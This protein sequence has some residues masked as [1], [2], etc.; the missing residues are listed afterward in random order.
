MSVPRLTLEQSAIIGAFT[1]VLCG[2]FSALHR[3]AEQ[4]LGT[5]I[6]THQFADPLVAAELKAAAREDFYGIC[7][8]E[9]GAGPPEVAR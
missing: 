8:A 6:W 2:P 5:P 1:G 3:Y 4:L 7:N 9:D